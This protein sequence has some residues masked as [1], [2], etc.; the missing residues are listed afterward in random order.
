MFYS[1]DKEGNPTQW[2]PAEIGP[3]LHKYVFNTINPGI[4]RHPEAAD[5]WPTCVTTTRRSRT[6][7]A[8]A[9]RGS[10]STGRS[11]TTRSTR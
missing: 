10:R 5:R 11:A 6:K 7:S 1:K 3:T 2:D 8:T 9:S 4:A